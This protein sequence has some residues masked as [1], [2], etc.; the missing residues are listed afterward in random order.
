MLK[1]LTKIKTWYKVHKWISIFVGV[2]FL[3]WLVSGIL[4][5]LPGRWFGSEPNTG[6]I[7]VDYNEMVISPAEAVGIATNDLT[8]NN[9][10]QMVSLKVILDNLIYEVDL[11]GGVTKLVDANSGEIFVMTPAIAEKIVRRDFSLETPSL[12]I[13][14]LKERNR[15]YPNGPLPVFQ[16][17]AEDK[18]GTYYF[19]PSDGSSSFR[20]TWLTRA[21]AAV[22]SLHDFSVL[23][24]IVNQNRV[25]KVLLLVVSLLAIV[26][27]IV[28][29]YLALPRRISRR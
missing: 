7:S 27:S 20:S 19:V 10:V 8:G 13:E 21:R 26:T 15:N 6:P 4:M 9:K 11:T 2:F 17:S 3:A 22:V 24:L 18:P 12:R 1:T 28:G 23:N 25:R 14:K 16:I 5:I 29:Y